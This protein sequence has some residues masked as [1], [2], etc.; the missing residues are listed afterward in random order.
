MAESFVFYKSFIECARMFPESEQLAILNDLI[1]SAIYDKEPETPAVFMM[2]Q[3]V[4]AA[5]ERYEKAV[6]N[7]AKGGRPS[8]QRYIPPEEWQAYYDT[9]T[10]KETAEHFGIPENTM[11]SWL[12]KTAYYKKGEKGENL[13]E[14]VTDN[15]TET[16]TVTLSSN[17]NNNKKNNKKEESLCGLA[18]TAPAGFLKEGET[19]V[20]EPYD[21]G[22]DFFVTV[23][24][25]DGE[26]VE[27]RV[28]T[29]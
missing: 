7:G 9:H 19:I 6:E 18:F 8:R 5:H 25:P 12:R 1:D 16:V 21:M 4:N 23:E 20:S 13:T 2:M 14:T 17:N 3:N 11:K 26:R 28:R 24:R 22:G 10:R 27:R 15:V 29:S